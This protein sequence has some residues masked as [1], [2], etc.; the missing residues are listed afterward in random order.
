MTPITSQVKEG[1]KTIDNIDEL[2]DLLH[3]DNRTT[4]WRKRKAGLIPEPDIKAGHPRWFRAS[5]ER[6]LPN[7]P[8]TP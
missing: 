4:F 2:M 6:S 7:L 1:M 5:L 8:T 3:I